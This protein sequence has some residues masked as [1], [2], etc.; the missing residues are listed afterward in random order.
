MKRMIKAAS[1]ISKV[2]EMEQPLGIQLVLKKNGFTFL[3]DVVEYDKRRK[4]IQDWNNYYKQYGGCRFV[5]VEP[6]TNIL[7]EYDRI[8]HQ[9][10]G[11]DFLPL[12]I[13]DK[14]NVVELYNEGAH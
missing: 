11:K 3:A 5:L 4:A 13:D 6:D 10:F 1:S 12:S 14:L 7:Y 9:L 2:E 8:A